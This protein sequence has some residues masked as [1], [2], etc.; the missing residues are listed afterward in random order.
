[1]LWLENWTKDSCR[2]ENVLGPERPVISY[3]DRLVGNRSRRAL[4]IQKNERKTK[5][6]HRYGQSRIGQNH[7]CQEAW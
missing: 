5:V 4:G 7:S 1:M 2:T 3:L 6:H